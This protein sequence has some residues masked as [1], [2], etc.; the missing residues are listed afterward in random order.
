MLSKKR[1]EVNDCVRGQY[2]QN[3]R[4]TVN[5]TFRVNVGCRRYARRLN[6]IVFRRSLLCLGTFLGSF[7]PRTLLLSSRGVALLGSLCE[8][9]GRLLWC[10]RV[11]R[12][13]VSS[14][15]DD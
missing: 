3:Q 9:N 6:A 2:S 15:P 1:G 12:G 11:L 4:L 14:L 8:R 5:C 10:T 7:A 13:R